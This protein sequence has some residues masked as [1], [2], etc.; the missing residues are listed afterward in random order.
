M[1][2]Q[3]DVMFEKMLIRELV[4]MSSMLKSMDEKLGRLLRNYAKA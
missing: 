3:Q 1:H 4:E 2:A